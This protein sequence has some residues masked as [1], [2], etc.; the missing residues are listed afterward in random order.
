MNWRGC[1]ARPV[2]HKKKKN[3]ENLFISIILQNNLNKRK[4]F[5][6]NLKDI[7]ITYA[8]HTTTDTIPAIS[9]EMFI[10][11]NDSFVM[12]FKFSLF[13]E[14]SFLNSLA[15]PDSKIEYALISTNAA[16]RITMPKMCDTIDDMYKA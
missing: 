16:N 5:Y 8:K 2:R 7:M 15:P 9:I 14:A 10:S 12:P 6:F 3:E 4:N 1:E 11:I 13:S